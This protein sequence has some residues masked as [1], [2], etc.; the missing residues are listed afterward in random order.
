[1]G[2]DRILFDFKSIDVYFTNDKLDLN[3]TSEDFK[4]KLEIKFNSYGPQYYHHI[5][6]YSLGTYG[7]IYFRK[8]VIRTRIN[9]IQRQHEKIA[10]FELPLSLNKQIELNDKFKYAIVCI[11]T[12]YSYAIKEIKI[13]KKDRTITS[14]DNVYCNNKFYSYNGSNGLFSSDIDIEAE[15]YYYDDDH[16]KEEGTWYDTVPEDSGLWISIFNLE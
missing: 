11:K 8:D 15:Y 4:R 14:K 10:A 12:N 7:D 2:Y 3:I 5:D 9:A 1:L 6:S 16:F 13:S